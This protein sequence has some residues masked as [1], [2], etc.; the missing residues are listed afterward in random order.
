[1]V[2]PSVVEANGGVKAGKINTYMASHAA[3]YGPFLLESY[4]PNRQAVLVANPKFFE[5]PASA[6]SSSTSSAPTHAAAAAALG[7]GR[8][9]PRPVEAVG[10]QPGQN[11]CCRIV[12]NDTP[13]AQQVVFNNT[14]G[15]VH[16]REFREAL[17]YA[18][19]YE[20]ILSKVVFGY[21]T[22]F[23][24]EWVP[25]FPWFDKTIGKPRPFDL[26]KAKALIEKSGVTTPVSS[27]T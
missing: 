26:N 13:F 3:G 19:P 21:G 27:P 18:V 12:A 14:S 10:Q 24:G 7:Q 17:T 22:L 20:D 4:E 16:Q 6:G 2:D 15:A 9:H 8:H 23:Y 25:Y 5:K 1:M 11:A